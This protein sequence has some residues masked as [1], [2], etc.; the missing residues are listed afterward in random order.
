MLL[1]AIVED[2]WEVSQ[3]INGRRKDRKFIPMPQHGCGGFEWCFFLPTET[4][5]DLESL[6][7]FILVDREERHCMAFRFECSAEGRHGYSHVQLTS[8]LKQGPKISGVPAWLPDSYP[9]FPIRAGNWTEMFLAMLTAV[10][11]YRGGVDK[12]ITE[13]FQEVNR[14]KEADKYADV[15]AARMLVKLH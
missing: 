5:G 10:H 1:N 4:E 13:I 11:G 2:D 8:R 14:T 9:A 6:T 3:V 7:L 15:L 12:V